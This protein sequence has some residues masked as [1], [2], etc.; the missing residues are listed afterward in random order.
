MPPVWNVLGE[1][2]IKTKHPFVIQYSN[3]EN[4]VNARASDSCLM[5]DYVRVINFRIIIIRPIIINVTVQLRYS[6]FMTS[7]FTKFWSQV[8]LGSFD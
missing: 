8:Y 2:D 4:N 6:E 3:I 5:L 1:R 7:N